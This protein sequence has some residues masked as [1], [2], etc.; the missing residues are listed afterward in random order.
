MTLRRLPDSAPIRNT[1]L[2]GVSSSSP[3]ASSLA[4]PCHQQLSSD[5]PLYRYQSSISL[6]LLASTV[7]INEIS[8]TRS[9]YSTSLCSV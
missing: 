3:R 7:D 5:R 4:F 9:A 6:R 1:C 8:I 2:K